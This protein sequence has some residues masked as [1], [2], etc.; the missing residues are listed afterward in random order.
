MQQFSDTIDVLTGEAV[1]TSVQ[2]FSDGGCHISLTIGEAIFSFDNTFE[3]NV[4]NNEKV[5]AVE[6]VNLFSSN[7]AKLLKITYLQTEDAPISVLWKVESG[8]VEIKEP[9]LY[10]V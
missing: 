3:Y 1:Q 5:I 6:T 7:T 2:L 9:K 10:K 8:I 4:Q